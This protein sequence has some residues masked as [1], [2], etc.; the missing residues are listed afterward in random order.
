MHALLKCGVVESEYAG[1]SKQRVLQRLSQTLIPF[2]SQQLGW[3]N[4]DLFCFLSTPPPKLP[5]LRDFYQGNPA[6]LKVSSVGNS[7]VGYVG[8]GAVAW[9]LMFKA[10]LGL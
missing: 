6:V 5:Q 10:L 8:L 1:F 7:S 2:L 9:A 3:E 4:T